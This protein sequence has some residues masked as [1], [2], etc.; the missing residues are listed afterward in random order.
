MRYTAEPP[1]CP[2][3]LSF[4]ALCVSAWLVLFPRP[5]LAA[6][7]PPNIL[8]IVSDDQGYH[9]LGCCGNRE[10][11]TPSLDRLAA[12]GVRLTDFYVTWPACTPSR[13]SLLTGRYPQRNGTYDMYRNDTVDYGHRYGLDEYAVSPEM[14]LGMDE[15][16][17][18]LPRVMR[19]AGYRSG[20]VGKWDLGQ[21]K[22][23]L[24]LA[25]GFDDFYGF[26]NTGIDY[27]THQ[28]YG[29]P[30][31]RRGNDLTTKDKGTYCTYLF[32]RE[33]LRFIRENKDRP[34]L[35][36]VPFNAPH[37]SSSLDPPVKG[38]VQ[39]P[40]EYVRQY[41]PGKTEKDR[42][43]VSYMAAVTC[44]DQSIGRI[45]DLLDELKLAQNT[46]VVFF[47]DNGGAK[48]AS[49]SPLRGWK[50]QMFEGGIRVPCIVRWPGRIAGGRVCDEFLT[51]LEVFPTVLAACGLQSPEGVVL[52]GFDMLPVLA[53]R[54]PSPRQEMFWQRRD[55]KAARVGS[56]KWI[57]SRAG[58]GLFDLTHDLGEAHDL[59]QEKPEVLKMVRD[60]FAAWERAMEQAEPRGPLRDY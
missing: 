29:I 43:R 52:D 46:L 19:P 57:E 40:E 25:R 20:I 18:L 24:P 4:A 60:R 45:L 48:I 36:Y 23:F 15:R 51:S 32:E 5:C 26:A 54:Q 50:S 35:A 10:I 49:N 17:V 56:W 9:D 30:S 8:I 39:A 41:P 47:S 6:E 13:G 27:V 11:K 22:R 59:S 28:R 42:K 1:F 34:F 31:M 3:R 53:G 14:V 2:Y 7:R 37:G 55:D 38:T 44:M 33:A 58:N 21:L 16:E 12:E